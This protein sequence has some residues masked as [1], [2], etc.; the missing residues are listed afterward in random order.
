M[1]FHDNLK[2]ALMVKGVSQVELA[3]AIKKT[4]STVSRYISGERKPG[5][6]TLSKIAQVLHMTMDELTRG[7]G[8]DGEI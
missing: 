4:E 5:I 8:D 1:S 2:R 3:D 6:K 7:E